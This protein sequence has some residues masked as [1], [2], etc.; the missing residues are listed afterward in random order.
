MAL[1]DEICA[2]AQQRIKI[3]A[4]LHENGVDVHI[5]C[6]SDGIYLTG[7]VARLAQRH[8]VEED[9]RVVAGDLAGGPLPIRI[10]N[11]LRVGERHPDG[12][13]RDKVFRTMIE[14][15][16]LDETKMWVE[17]D[18]GVVTLRGEVESFTK[19]RL[20]GAFAWWTPGTL[21]VRNELAV[22]HP[23]EDS[24]ELLAEAIELVF[25][26]DPLVNES[27][28][29]VITHDGLVHLIGTVASDIAR[30]AAEQDAWAVLGTERVVNDLESTP[31]PM[32][33]PTT[34]P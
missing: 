18:D 10:V 12:E 16:Y 11:E 23:E 25:D 29:T 9:V 4:R 13:V 15:P 33:P 26:K 1:I 21:D 2:Q 20:A 5:H 22:L 30:D 32:Q 31:A 17:V 14:D 24:E 28:V 3:D 8:Y 27:E 7:T 34:G 19:K 6:R